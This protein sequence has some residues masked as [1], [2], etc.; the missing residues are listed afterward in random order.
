MI[1]LNPCKYTSIPEVGNDSFI[2]LL[3][4]SKNNK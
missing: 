2:Q 4:N 1:N 3:A